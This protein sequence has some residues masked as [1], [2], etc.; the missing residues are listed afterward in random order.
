MVSLVDELAGRIVDCCA[1]DY[2]KS[3]LAGGRQIKRL[4]ELEL[5]RLPLYFKQLI[6][7]GNVIS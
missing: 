6:G 3:V 2:E 1:T 4:H 5:M 7:N